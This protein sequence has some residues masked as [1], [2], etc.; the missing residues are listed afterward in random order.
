MESDIEI[1]QKA[2]MNKVV[3]VA[4]A[5]GIPEDSIEPY[6]HYKGKIALSYLETLKKSLTAN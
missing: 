6:G 4:S 1:A 5:L 3:N 2:K